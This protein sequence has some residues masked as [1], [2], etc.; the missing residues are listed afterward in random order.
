MT[1]S[2]HTSTGTHPLGEEPGP[3]GTGTTGQ[4][5]DR[6]G[7]ERDSSARASMWDAVRKVRTRHLA[8]AKQAGEKFAMLTCYDFLTAQVFDA[9]GIEV[10]LVGDSAGNN[11]LGHDSTLNITVDQLIPLTAAVAAGAQ[12]S[13]VLADLPFGSYQLSPE[14]AVA[15]AVRFMKEGNAHAV[16]MEV[17]S[18]L[19]DH[20]RAVV[21]AGIPV[22][23]HIGFTPQSEH[24]L[25]GFRV[26]G[27]GSAAADLVDA[28]LAMEA[29]GAFCLLL[30]MTTAESAAAV[31]AAVSIPTVGIGAGGST[32]GQVLVW[33]DAFGLR[34]GKLPRFVKQYADLYGTLHEAAVA[35]RTDVCS[36]AYPAPE[37][38]FES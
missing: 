16:K 29:A 17:H 13:L 5:P 14:Q 35:F 1:Q 28:A 27:R 33:Q 21:N 36:G 8:Q 12:R 19:T 18:G 26:Q 37:H 34:R 38:T 7:A 4:A 2:E 20:V 23:A 22:V 30:E 9:A 11:V 24:A 6:P 3:Y 32:T 25:G 15:T 31:E 10:L